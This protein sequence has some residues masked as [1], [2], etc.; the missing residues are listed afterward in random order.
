M[1]CEEERAALR[2][3]REREDTARAAADTVTETEPLPPY[4]LTD[5]VAAGDMSAL[6]DE[7]R[8][9]AAATKEARE[10]LARC[11]EAEPG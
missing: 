1:A 6:R 11:L 4:P 3:A 9:A 7:L 2:L 5:W 10:R 8:A